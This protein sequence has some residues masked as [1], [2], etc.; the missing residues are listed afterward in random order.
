MKRVSK[1]LAVILLPTALGACMFHGGEPKH[2]STTTIGQ[3]LSDL[4]MAWD[5]GAIT[6]AEYRTIKEEFVNACAHGE[7]HRNHH[8]C[9]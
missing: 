2:V 7:H 3:E 6:E 8:E 5:S 1:I 4:K 9:R